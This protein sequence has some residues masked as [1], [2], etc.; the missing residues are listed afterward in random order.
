[1]GLAAYG[2]LEGEIFPYINLDGHD[3]FPSYYKRD[4]DAA[5]AEVAHDRQRASDQLVPRACRRAAAVQPGAGDGAHHRG[6]VRANG[7]HRL[8]PCRRHRAELLVQRQARRVCPMSALSSSNRP[9]GTP[10]LHSAQP[11]T[12]TCSARGDRPPRDV[13][14]RVL[15]RR[16]L[17]R[18]D[19]RGAGPAKVDYRHV[20]DIASETAALLDENKIV[21]W[22]QGR[23]EIGPRALGARSI[24]ANPTDR[25]A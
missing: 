16:V 24:L 13:R 2:D 18:R 1:M 10:A 17:E 8:L 11:S 6:S 4:L 7:S 20:D 14:P 9:Q 19:P 5:L 15:G 23:M 25:R 12:H 21:G 3:G 22:F